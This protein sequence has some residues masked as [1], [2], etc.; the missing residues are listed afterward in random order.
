LSA[1]ATFEEGEADFNAVLAGEGSDIVLEE[2]DCLLIVTERIEDHFFRR[3]SCI[4]FNF[5][6]I[7][8]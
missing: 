3:D 6:H 5:D 8:L 1:L 4:Y 2:L 7:F